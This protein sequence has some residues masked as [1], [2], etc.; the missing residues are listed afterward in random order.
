MK[1]F[2]YLPIYYTFY[3][4]LINKK[5]RVA[6]CFTYLFPVF[7]TIYDLRANLW[8]SIFVGAL[9]C[10]ATY[11][12]YE[13]GYII[14]DAVLIKKEINPTLR[15]TAH[16]ITYA[17]N[18]RVLIFLFRIFCLFLLVASSIYF[19][20]KLGY[21][22]FFSCACIFILYYFYNRIRSRWNIPLYSLLVFFRYFGSISLLVEPTQNIILWL[23]YPLCVTIEFCKKDKYG[24]KSLTLIHS[25]DK[26]RALY[27]SLI[28]F[29]WITFYHGALPLFSWL[30]IYFFI[31]RFSSLLVFDFYRK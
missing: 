9:C 14:N 26:F 24:F 17:N 2:F 3:T 10:L 19:D 1:L 27:Y 16:E 4:R 21:S 30:L 25:V 13:Y 28:L 29:T 22:L 12:I 8:E 6:W 5:S 7:L 31:Y 11:S 18:H 23:L 15:L 20:E